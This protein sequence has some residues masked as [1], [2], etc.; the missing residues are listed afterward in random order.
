MA[1]KA[2]NDASIAVMIIGFLILFP[3]VTIIKMIK[4]AR[5]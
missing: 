1:S 2:L 3:I 5:E 4:K